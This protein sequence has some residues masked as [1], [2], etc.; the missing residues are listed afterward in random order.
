M[1]GNQSLYGDFWYFEFERLIEPF[2][3][4]GGVVIGAG[5]LSPYSG[6]DT[7]PSMSVNTQGSIFRDLIWQHNFPRPDASYTHYG[8]AVDYRGE[9]PTVYV[10]LGDEVA[11]S[12]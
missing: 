3:Q 5:N 6:K 10:I 8:L 12:V 9:H 4:G 7:P 2:N 1:R 11:F